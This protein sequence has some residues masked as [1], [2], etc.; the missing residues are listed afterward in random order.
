MAPTITLYTDGACVNHVK[1]GGPGGWAAILVACDDIGNILKERE[2]A[3]GAPQTTN[4]RMEMT[5][6]IEGLKA[7][8]KTVPVTV[9]TDSEYV[10]DTMEGRLKRKKNPD[11]W[12]ELDSLCLQH[13]VS[14]EWTRGHS[15]HH[16]NERC[17]ELAVEQ[18][19]RYKQQ[20][21]D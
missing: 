19:D 7:L 11:L 8:T 12:Q 6:V 5:A 10:K 9:V 16:Y 4:N 20:D 15:G 21:G 14:W 3:G 2:L 1:G 18:R 13:T 17:D